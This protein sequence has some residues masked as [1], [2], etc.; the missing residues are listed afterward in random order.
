MTSAQLLVLLDG[1]LAA[2]SGAAAKVLLAIVAHADRSGRAWPSIGR[3]AR[4]SGLHRRTV[5][6]ALRELQGLGLIE[7]EARP[8]SSSTVQVVVPPRGVQAPHPR[9]PARP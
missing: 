1:R 2:A 3:L 9:R 5:Q 6:R 4:A 7:L 8:G